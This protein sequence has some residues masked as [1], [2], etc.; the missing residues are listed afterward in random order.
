LEWK[1]ALELYILKLKCRFL[2]FARFHARL[3]LRHAMVCNFSLLLSP[4]VLEANVT[5]V[6]E[7]MC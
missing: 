7:A 2:G 5:V 6:L 3:H 1:L 4:V